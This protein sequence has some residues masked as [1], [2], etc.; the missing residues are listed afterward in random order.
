MAVLWA[1]CRPRLWANVGAPDAG[2][3]SAWPLRRDAQ[4]S[5]VQASGDP[6]EGKVLETLVGRYVWDGLGEAQRRSGPQ[7]VLRCRRVREQPSC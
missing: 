2:R 5:L 1:G 3:L 6:C 4:N 7:E